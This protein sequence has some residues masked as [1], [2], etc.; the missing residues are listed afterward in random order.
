MHPVSSVA[1]LAFLCCLLVTYSTANN[2]AQLSEESGVAIYDQ[3]AEIREGDQRDAT[4]PLNR[5]KRTLFLKKKLI[6]AGLL[7]FG[8]GIAKGYKA[9]YYSAPQVRHVYLSSP[10]PSTKYVEYV[11]KPIYVERII[12]RPAPVFKPIHVEYAAESSPY[13]S[14]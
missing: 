11:E 5:Q 10:P 4:T 9:G 2:D 12:E 8:L 3:G 14:W 7:G 6:G 1:I 13:G